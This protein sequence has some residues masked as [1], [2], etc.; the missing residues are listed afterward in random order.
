MSRAIFTALLREAAP[1]TARATQEIEV[2]RRRREITRRRSEFSGCKELEN[3]TVAIV[4][5]GLAGLMAA[6]VLSLQG[7]QVRL[8]EANKELGGRVRSNHSFCEGRITEE[9]AELVGSM[10][11]TWLALAREYG[12]GLITRTDGD[13]HA[14]LGLEVKVKLDKLLAWTEVMQVVIDLRNRILEKFGQDARSILD[15]SRPWIPTS[16][17]GW[18]QVQRWDGMSVGDKLSNLG[19]AK[20]SRLWLAMELLLRNN[21]VA[22]LDELN[23]LGLLCLIKGHKLVDRLGEHVEDP[24]LLGYWT[25]LEIFR[26]ADGCQA[27]VHGLERELEGREPASIQ[28][29]AMVTAIDLDKR[30]LKWARAIGGA[31][32]FGS[33]KTQKFDYVILDIP[34]TV[35]AKVK[36]IKPEHP[37]NTALA[38]FGIGKAAKFFSNVKERFWIKQG[39]AP[40]GGSVDFGQVWEG[41]DNQTTARSRN[42]G[43]LLNVFAGDRILTT[44]EYKNGLEGLYPGYKSQLRAAKLV[45]WSKEL[46]IETGYA[47]PKKG[48]ILTLGQRLNQPFHDILF[49]AGEHTQMNGFGYMEG[50]LLSGE[51]AA[52]NVMRKVCNVRSQVA[53]AES[54]ALDEWESVTDAELEDLYAAVLDEH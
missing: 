45:D 14:R 12:L 27:V 41:T 18:L 13:Y 32:Q 29:S 6:K 16:P 23:Y 9:G 30:E 26:C 39:A 44:D 50:A 10:H 52:L 4:G 36:D 48:Q 47:S 7:V 21:N 2:E 31:P 25:E 5:G 22:P 54:P 33:M 38:S 37:K 40:L 19:I 43:I 11:L 3:T 46:F 35:W 42:Q 8:F 1:S 49:F 20:G 51:R 34:P 15:P 24:H 28:A 17:T 53:E